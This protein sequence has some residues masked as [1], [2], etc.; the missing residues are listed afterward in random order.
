MCKYVRKPG[1]AEIFSHIVVVNENALL[2]KGF[3]GMFP[4]AFS[5]AHFKSIAVRFAAKGEQA[6]EISPAVC[7]GVPPGE[8]PPGEEPP[9]EE[10]PGD[11]GGIVEEQDPAAAAGADVVLPDTGTPPHLQFLAL[12]GGLC[13]LAGAW[14]VT[15]GVRSQR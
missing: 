15:R 14:L 11:V 4:F 6:R 5:D 9:G 3:A 10:P 8:E 2:G 7:P 12:L 1:A 13:S